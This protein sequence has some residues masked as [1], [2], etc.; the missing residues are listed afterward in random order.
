MK[1]NLENIFNKF[2][3]Q[4]DIEEPTIG[5]F[6][7]FEKKL[8]TNKTKHKN[9][10]NIFSKIAIAA[11]IVLFVGIWIGQSFNSNSGM[12]LAQVSTEME[13]TQSYFVSTIHKELETIEDER[14]ADTEAII[15]DALEQLQILENQYQ[16]L[17]LELNESAEDKRIIY[18]MIS[19]FQQRIDLLQ[20][21]L[22]Q[23]ENVK[24]LKQNNN[25]TYV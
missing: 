11:S 12:E 20:S 22:Q 25:E 9:S 7:R 4:F 17:S 19:N 13:E 2:E 3:N 5:H 21:L 16:K 6:N 23:I 18:A 10:F 8:N 14:N 1:D 24:Q 15:N